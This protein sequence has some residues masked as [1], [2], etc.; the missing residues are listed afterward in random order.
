[1]QNDVGNIITATPAFAVSPQLKT[2]IQSYSLSVLLS[3]KLAQYRGELPV[4][5]VWNILKKHGSDLPPGI[6]NIPADMKT[7]TS[8][9]QEQLTQARSSCKKKG[10]VRIIRVDDKKNKI[11]IE[12]EPSQHQNLFALAQCFVDGTKCR[13]TN[14]LCGRIALMRDVYLANSGTSF[15]TDLD[16]ALVLMRQ[17]AEGSEDARDA[18]FEDLIETDKKLH[19]AVD[20]IYQSTHDLQQEVDDLI[21]ATSA[22]AAS[23]AT[24]RDCSPPPE[25][26]SDQLDADGGGGAEAVD[27]NS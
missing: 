19:G 12:L 1:M 26:D 22:D 11:T 6:E 21:D 16:N 3:P 9:I 2:N 24:R 20:I 18:M 10:I 4:Q 14:A 8:E 15:W 23:T 7:L 25:G 27:T 5:H 17:V 13:I